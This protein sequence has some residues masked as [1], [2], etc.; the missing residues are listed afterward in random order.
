MLAELRLYQL[1]S[2]ALPV[3]AFTYSQGLEWAIECGWVSD[4]KSLNE[5]LSSVLE[6]SVASLEA[7]VLFR[8][9]DALENGD[10][11][12]FN[13]WCRYLIASRESSE[14]RAEERQRA[15]ALMRLLP[16]LEVPLPETIRPGT[17]TTQL[18]GMAQA[19]RHWG[20]DSRSLCRGYLWSWLENAV[21]AGVKLVP[22]GQTD[23]QQLLM[24][25]SETLPALLDQAA[26]IEDRDVGSSTPALAIASS[27][28]ET[29][30]SRLFRS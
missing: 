23:G 10:N 25:L 20:I 8:L 30:Y 19:A 27:L 1:I 29:Q 11:Q 14:L 6:H 2:P 22:L 28:H 26:K 17:E 18:A 4:K 12:R 13:D 21:M 24:R 15:Q 3:G 9:S 5:W 7:P 16:A